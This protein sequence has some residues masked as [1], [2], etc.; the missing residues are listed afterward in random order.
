MTTCS[1]KYYVKVVEE[2][3]KRAPIQSTHVPV[4]DDSSISLLAL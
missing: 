3:G 1:G 4:R 2:S